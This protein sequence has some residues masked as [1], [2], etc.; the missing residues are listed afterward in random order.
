MQSGSVSIRSGGTLF[1]AARWLA[2]QFLGLM[3]LSPIVLLGVFFIFEKLAGGQLPWTLYFV[4]LAVSAPFFV[5]VFL[6]QLLMESFSMPRSALGNIT[7]A[8]LTV[9]GAVGAEAEEDDEFGDLDLD[10]DA[11][12]SGR[13]EAIKRWL[14]S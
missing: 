2:I 12:D 1:R 6:V 8:E 13:I 7:D 9:L 5:V 4:M 11:E 3:L 14:A 10:I